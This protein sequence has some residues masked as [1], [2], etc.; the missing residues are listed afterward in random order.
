MPSRYR[1][2]WREDLYI[3]DD[4]DDRINDKDERILETGTG[5]DEDVVDLLEGDPSDPGGTWDIIGTYRMP[6]EWRMKRISL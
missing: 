5:A 3:R 4:E 2:R 6:L 1:L